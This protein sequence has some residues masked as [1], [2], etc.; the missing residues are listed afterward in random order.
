MRYIKSYLHEQEVILRDIEE[1]DIPAIVEYWHQN[2]PEYF[3]SIGVDIKKIRSTSDTAALFRGSIGA[4]HV[5]GN[6]ITLVVTVDRQVAGYTNINLKTN[7]EG[8]AHVHIIHPRYR[9]KGI[10]AYLYGDAIKLIFGQFGMRRL[11]FQTSV[12]NNRINALLAKQGIKP[13]EKIFIEKPDG[14]AK[15]G[16][17]YIYELL[18]DQFMTTLSDKVAI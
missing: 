16:E 14:M 17:F 8:Y 10:A 6:R 11:G 4:K 15:P 12:T 1:E 18:C 5:A 3:D 13:L 9:N 7:D 2:D